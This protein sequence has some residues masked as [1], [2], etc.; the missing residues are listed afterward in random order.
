MKVG[1]TCAAVMAAISLA[2]SARACSCLTGVWPWPPSGSTIPTNGIVILRGNEPLHRDLIAHV[3]EHRPALACGKRLVPLQLKDLYVGHTEVKALL[4]PARAL[5]PLTRC[6]LVLT[7]KPRVGQPPINW[8]RSL[9]PLG[10]TSEPPWWITS[11]GAD[12]RR[13]TW[14]AAP[15]WMGQPERGPR[16]GNPDGRVTVKVSAPATDTEGPVLVYVFL[17]DGHEK[18]DF[19]IAPEQETIDVGY[20]M[21]GGAFEL[22]ENRKYRVRLTAMDAAGNETGAPGKLSGITAP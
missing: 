13:P 18:N 1:I 8:I 5:P 19:V 12:H 3:N 21:C 7:A 20:D 16:C 11:T 17:D 22:E 9:D 2:P 15:H 6:D 14:G 10:G 4:V